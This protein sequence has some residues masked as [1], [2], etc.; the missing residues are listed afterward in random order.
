MEQ[1]RF[2]IPLFFTKKHRKY[3]EKDYLHFHQ[4]EI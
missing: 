1:E 3:G 2:L 4:N